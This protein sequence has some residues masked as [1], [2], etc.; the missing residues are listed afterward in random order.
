MLENNIFRSIR[1]ARLKM[2]EETH[3][4][5]LQVKISIMTSLMR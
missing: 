1:D 3:G 4:N 5:H 2:K